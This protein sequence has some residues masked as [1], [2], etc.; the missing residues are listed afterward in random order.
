LTTSTSTTASVSLSSSSSSS[1]AA[2]I[3]ALSD[4][5]LHVLSSTDCL[6]LW[7][8]AIPN[9]TPI[10]IVQ[11]SEGAGASR[12]TVR[13]AEPVH[14]QYE[15]EWIEAVVT[16]S[17]TQPLRSSRRCCSG[18]FGAWQ[19]SCRSWSS[20][21][22]AWAGFPHHGKVTLFVERPVQK[23]SLTL[24]PFAGNV[25][26]CHSFKVT[27]IVCPKSPRRREGSAGSSALIR[28]DNNEATDSVVKIR[29]VD[30]V[31]L[32]PYSDHGGDS[33]S[34]SCCG[35]WSDTS[36]SCG[37]PLQDYVDQTVASLIRLRFL[38]EEQPRWEPATS[39]MRHPNETQFQSHSS[40]LVGGSD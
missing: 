6:P 29:I 28:H 27:P 1:V 19:S 31:R 38:V 17:L 32:L 8:D 35:L 24:G 14:R 20:S 25:Q 13:P 5:I 30:T 33:N 9:H 7:C 22:A 12:P 36:W 2:A 18:I 16:A 23:V 10:V 3:D 21:L 40:L 39:I 26:V 15:G 11:S 4:D 37:V 34:V